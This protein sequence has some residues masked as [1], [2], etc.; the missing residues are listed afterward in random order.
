METYVPKIDR[1]YAYLR[2]FHSGRENA[3]CN[4]ELRQALDCDER[5]VRRYIHRL[6][7][8]GHPICS[9]QDGYYY[10]DSVEDINETIARLDCMQKKLA[11]ARNSL[12]CS[13]VVATLPTQI[14]IRL[15]I[16]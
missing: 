11:D 1:L 14:E 2:C 13:A 5:T 12:S 8:E 3:A 9:G 15:T 7:E 10:A 16:H 6:R 4:K